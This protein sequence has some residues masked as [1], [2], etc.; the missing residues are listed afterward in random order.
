M[1]LDYDRYR[2]RRRIH[3]EK[4]AGGYLGN[5]EYGGGADPWAFTWPSLP[6]GTD[7]LLG[8]EG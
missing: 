1:R 5:G 6:A 3:A 2:F 4:Q 8:C 7:L